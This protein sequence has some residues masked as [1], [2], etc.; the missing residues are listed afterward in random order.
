MHA[1]LSGVGCAGLLGFLRQGGNWIYAGFFLALLGAVVVLAVLLATTTA[2][3]KAVKDIKFTN[4]VHTKL[5]DIVGTIL[6]DGT[7][8]FLGLPYA[9]TGPVR[10]V[11][12][13]LALA[14][15]SRFTP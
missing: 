8:Q 12:S 14:S 1:R 5:G 9:H 10:C 2:G 13:A 11:Q 7:R 6:P 3:S 4:T 15:R